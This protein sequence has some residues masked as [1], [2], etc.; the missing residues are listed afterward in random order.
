VTL[1]AMLL[2]LISGDTFV[3]DASAEA[4]YIVNI[5]REALRGYVDDI[6]LF[7]RNMPGVVGVTSLGD[8]TFL[9]RTEKDIPLKGPMKVDFHIRKFVLSDTLTVYRSVNV[10]DTNYMSCRVALKPHDVTQTAITISLR[11]RMER[12][13]PA[14]IH[15]LAPVLGEDFI[16]DRMTEDL[17]DMLREF[18]DSSN[19]ELYA[20]IPQT[21]MRN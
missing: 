17:E 7:E 3:A 18:I 16:S 2:V 12:E 5:S 9:Y 19:R 6:G 21:T 20:R 8:E 10:E 15:W 1:L 4:S 11:V 14:D 13:N